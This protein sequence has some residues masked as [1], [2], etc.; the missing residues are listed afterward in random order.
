MHGLI[1]TGGDLQLGSTRGFPGV[2]FTY[3]HPYLQKPA[4]VSRGAG[5]QGCGLW[6][7]PRVLIMLRVFS[8]SG[9]IWA[10]LG[11]IRVT[12]IYTIRQMCRPCNSMTINATT[13]TPTPILAG[14]S[15]NRHPVPAANTPPSNVGTRCQ[16]GEESV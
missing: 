1:G 15:T 7:F 2:F 8:Y 10:T 6:V 3:P 13:I 12:T 4:P 9:M 16:M 11:Y 14:T 5:F